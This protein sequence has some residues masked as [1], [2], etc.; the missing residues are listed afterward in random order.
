M[1]E[2]RPNTALDCSRGGTL[3]SKVK[4][5]FSK[6]ADINFIY[7][8]FKRTGLLI[9]P[10]MQSKRTALFGDFTEIGDFQAA[11]DK[12]VRGREVF[13]ALPAHIRDRFRNDP[14]KLLDF[15]SDESNREEAISLGLVPEA[16]DPP[17]GGEEAPDPPKGGEEGTA[18]AE[19]PAEPKES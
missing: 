10:A 15:M 11:Q 3:P 13:E 14:A 8:R 6:E 17:K 16:P 9:D 7:N 1:A 4:Q 19:P 12:I 5:S 18:P 2:E